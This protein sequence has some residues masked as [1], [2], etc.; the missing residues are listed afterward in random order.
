LKRAPIDE[1]ATD[2]MPASKA[3]EMLEKEAGW[4]P[5][6]SNF[7]NSEPLKPLL[8]GIGG[9]LVP[10]DTPAIS[11]LN[12]DGKPIRELVDIVVPSIRDLDFLE[13]WKPFIEGF[14]LIL[15]QDGDPKKQLKIPAWADY[16]LYNRDDIERALGNRSW[17]ISKK[18]A[19][20]RN[21]GFLISDKKFV[22]TLDDD[23]LPAKDASG[24]LIN[25]I[26]EHVVNLMTPSTPFFFNTVYD[27]YRPG[28]DFVRGYPFSLRNGVPTGVSHGLWMNAYDYDA[29]TQLLKVTER[30]TRYVDATLTIPKG[31]LYPMCSMN[32]V[33]LLTSKTRV[34]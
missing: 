23:C 12:F 7:V 22:Y 16:E 25:S 9:K 20:I 34:L 19:S 11:L 18:D 6:T 31:V 33:S 4:N 14:H 15:V 28:S 26:E 8:P 24:K 10:A 30:N 5:D 17:I 32:V 27:P 3:V 13:I 21:F 29:P 2:Y 1:A